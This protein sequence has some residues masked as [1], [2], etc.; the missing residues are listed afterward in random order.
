MSDTTK[1]DAI[2]AQE[3]AAPD[4][5]GANLAKTLD[6]IDELA[7]KV[8]MYADH[9]RLGVFRSQIFALTAALRS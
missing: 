7:A 5:A 6:Q 2:P 4:T 9:E 8:Q 1:K 3:D